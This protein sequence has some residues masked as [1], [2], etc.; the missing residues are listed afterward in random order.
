MG[1]QFQSFFDGTGWKRRRNRYLFSSIT[2]IS[3]PC[4]W[5]ESASPSFTRVNVCFP[6]IVPPSSFAFFKFKG[7][8]SII[9]KPTSAPIW[10][11]YRTLLISTRFCP[12]VWPPTISSN[13]NL[14]SVLLP[15]PECHLA[16]PPPRF[17][18]HVAF[19]PY[20]GFHSLINL[21]LQKKI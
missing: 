5:T 19:I 21:A 8:T 9:S 15:L 11:L 14:S 10:R 17:L 13:P 3:S 7:Q 6:R 16:G 18:C 12:P 2:L 4:L 20:P 1:G